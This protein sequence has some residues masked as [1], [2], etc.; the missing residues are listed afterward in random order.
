MHDHVDLQQTDQIVQKEKRKSRRVWANPIILFVLTAAFAIGVVVA[1][2]SVLYSG[3]GAAFYLPPGGSWQKAPPL[4]GDPDDIQVSPQ[5]KVWVSTAFHGGLS[6]FDGS[7]WQYYSGPDFGT[8]E[9]YLWGGFTLVGEQVWG[10]TQSAAIH[11]DG[12]KWTHYAEALVSDQPRDIAA[13]ESEVWIID[14]KGNL[15]HFDGAHWTTT[16]LRNALPNVQ[17]T[18]RQYPALTT[19]PDGSLWLSSDGLWHFDRMN[20][21]EVRPAGTALKGAGF[22]GVTRDRIWLWDRHDLTWITFDRS[23]WGH[24]NTIDLGL[25]AD[26]EIY[27]VTDDNDQLKAIANKG[28][29]TF[30]GVTWHFSAMPA[31]DMQAI[32]HAVLSHDGAVWAIGQTQIAIVQR[33]LPLVLVLIVGLGALILIFVSGGRS[34]HNLVKSQ[35][36]IGEVVVRSVP[37]AGPATPAPVMSSRKA[38]VFIV[39]SLIGLP[40][41]IVPLWRAIDDWLGRVWPDAPGWT[42]AV[43]IILGAVLISTTGSR[44]IVRFRS[45]R[46][47]D[48]GPFGRDLL[49]TLG[50]LV[51]F[52]IMLLVIQW[53]ISGLASIVNN[54]L[55]LIPIVLLVGMFGFSLVM[56]GLIFLPAYWVNG[57]LR[58]ADYAKALK[59]IAILEKWRGKSAANLFMEGTIHLFAGRYQQAEQLLRASLAEGQRK[60]ALLE[61]SAALDNLGFALMEQRRYDEAIKAFEGAIEIKA[62]RDGPYNY[63]AEAYLR[64][65]LEPQRALELIDRALHNKRATALSRRID[66]H[67]FGEMWGN[68]AWALALL[69]R[70]A[71]A[72][73]SIERGFAETDQNFKPGLAG[74][75]WRVGQAQRARGDFA[76]AIGHFTQA[77]ELDPIGN[78]GHLSAQALRDMGRNIV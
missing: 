39:L 76:K 15:S 13:S 44:L 20:W 52:G 2:Q 29:L 24:Y 70:H 3:A 54:P 60:G 43:L 53:L 57:A 71:E 73:E 64:Q 26:A 49:R 38:I 25:P 9:N 66:R 75:H 58:R 62:D 36:Q 28:I 63:L 6:R 16:N 50:R 21:A 40:L 48:M 1:M 72:L 30:D 74:L 47:A 8:Q 4:A 27:Q 65:G 5:G 37:E 34:L 41:L 17:W 33:I 59:R 11:F 42:P 61:Q 35:Q 69:G 31:I 7:S 56:A 23:Q 18:D 12:Q 55:W 10:A 78:Y 19:T 67:M 32:T 22:V 77:R 14:T 45:S 51:L 46:Q 68:R